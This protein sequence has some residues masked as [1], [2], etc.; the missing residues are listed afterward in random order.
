MTPP[1]D[2]R[3]YLANLPSIEDSERQIW[4]DVRKI[5]ARSGS[6]K[7][8]KAEAERIERLRQAAKQKRGKK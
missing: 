3:D 2:M 6:A 7:V 8:A 1:K 4:G 5:R